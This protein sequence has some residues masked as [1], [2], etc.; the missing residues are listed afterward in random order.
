MVKPVFLPA[1]SFIHTVSLGIFF[2]GE[3]QSVECSGNCDSEGGIEDEYLY[4]IGDS[5]VKSSIHIL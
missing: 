2:L 3:V 5:F 1:S 4:I